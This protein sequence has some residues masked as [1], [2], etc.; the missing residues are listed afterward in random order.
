MNIGYFNNPKV[1]YNR[2]RVWLIP[3]TMKLA[4]EENAETLA[5]LATEWENP[6]NAHKKTINDQNTACIAVISQ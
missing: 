3:Q 4:K 1:N 6:E 2:F 5:L